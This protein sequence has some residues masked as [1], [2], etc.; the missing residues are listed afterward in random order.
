MGEPGGKPSLVREITTQP[1]VGTGIEP[2][3]PGVNHT[4]VRYSI[5]AV[6]APIFFSIKGLNYFFVCLI[7]KIECVSSPGIFLGL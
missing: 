1:G 6:L 5:I 2:V 4:T 3:T 7:P